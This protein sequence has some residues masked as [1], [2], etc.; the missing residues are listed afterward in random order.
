MSVLWRTRGLE[1][2]LVSLA[3]GLPRTLEPCTC[4]QSDS[5]Q[6]ALEQSQAVFLGVVVSVRDLDVVK[7]S[8]AIP[9]TQGFRFRLSRAWKGVSTETVEVGTSSMGTACGFDFDVG[10]EYLVYAGSGGIASATTSAVRGGS[11]GRA[12]DRPSLWTSSCSRTRH[13]RVAENGDLRALGEPAWVSG[14][15]AESFLSDELRLASSEGNTE[16]VRTL[17]AA[18]HDVNARDRRHGTTALKAAAGRGR[19]ETVRALLAAGADVRASKAGSTALDVA[20]EGGHAEVVR[21]LLEAGAPGGEQSL[22]VAAYRRHAAVLEVLLAEGISV[23]GEPGTAALAAAAQGND[24]AI[25]RRLLEAGADPARPSEHQSALDAAAAKG[26]ADMIRLLLAK[27]ARPSRETLDAAVQSGNREAVRLLDEPL[28]RGGGPAKPGPAALVR[29]AIDG[30]VAGIDLALESGVDVN[31]TDRHGSTALM[32]AVSTGRLEAVRRLLKAGAKP[33]QPENAGVRP[34]M[35]AAANGNLEMLKLLL[36]AGADIEAQ[37]TWEGR[38]R[39]TA[40]RFAV[41][42]DQTQAVAFLLKAGANPNAPGWGVLSGSALSEAVFRG[43]VEIARLLVQGGADV[44]ARRMVGWGR[45]EPDIALEAAPLSV[46][47]DKGDAQMVELLLKA[48][49]RI[50][51]LDAGGHTALDRAEQRRHQEVIALLRRAAAKP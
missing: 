12:H 26:N 9:L 24:V 45:A 50:G 51:T 33:N 5:P 35:R 48:G 13:F 30:N 27:G 46:A 40:L 16:R 42:I 15:R 32:A 6:A 43:N 21:I 8:P 41:G 39:G 28:R 2:V 49:A 7:G 31:A 11:V 44:N 10:E 14:R 25:V 23:R 17:I 22:V 47:A 18:G 4:L 36:D 1:C 29:A 19:A 20:V 38:N 3:L 37:Q 34:L